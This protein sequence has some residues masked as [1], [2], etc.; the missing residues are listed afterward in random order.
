MSIDGCAILK[1]IWALIV[2]RQKYNFS[3]LQKIFMDY[4]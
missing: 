3:E 4:S 1:T 2:V